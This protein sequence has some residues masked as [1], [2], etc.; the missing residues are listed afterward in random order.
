M[1]V[2]RYSNVILARPDGEIVLCA[3]QVGSKMSSARQLQTGGRYQ[4][5]PKPQGIPPDLAEPLDTWQHNVWQAAHMVSTKTGK[6]ASVVDGMVRAYQVRHTRRDTLHVPH[7]STT[8][9]LAGCRA[10]YGHGS[11]VTHAGYLTKVQN[12]FFWTAALH[13][14]ESVQVWSSST[15]TA[16]TS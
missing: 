5:P 12:A 2:C 4:L 9:H 8:L 6:P 14:I 1:Q 3:Y 10:V 15:S 11:D 7:V 13:I 16:L